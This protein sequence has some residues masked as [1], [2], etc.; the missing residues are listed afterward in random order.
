MLL[1]RLFTGFITLCYLKPLSL[2]FIKCIQFKTYY[3]QLIFAYFDLKCNTD[4]LNGVD[5]L[6]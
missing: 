1:K 5:T 6:R 2:K 4:C 3:D